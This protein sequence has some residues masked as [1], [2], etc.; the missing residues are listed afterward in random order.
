M[1]KTDTERFSLA[2]GVHEYKGVIYQAASTPEILDK[3]DTADIK[4][5]DWMV[6]TYP[7]SGQFDHYKQ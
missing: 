2:G 6:A 1:F 7:K 4:E 3:L 5:G